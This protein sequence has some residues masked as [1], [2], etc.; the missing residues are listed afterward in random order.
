MTKFICCLLL[1]LAGSVMAP[2]QYKIEKLN[3]I[4]PDKLKLSDGTL[5]YELLGEGSPVVLLH[6]GGLDLHMWDKQANTFAKHFRI[7]RY[8]L[9]GHGQSAPATGTFSDV[10]DLKMLLDH[11]GYKKVSLV[12]LSRG[13]GVALNFTLDHPERVDKLVLVSASGPPPGVPVAEGT[14]VLTDTATHYRLKEIGVPVLI[15]VGDGDSPRVVGAAD[16]AVAGIKGARKVVIPNARHLVN[17]ENQRA[18]DE[19]VIRFLS[20]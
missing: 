7:I 1:I 13:S 2:A 11:L 18:F 14:V 3:D 19:E 15:V 12:G 10:D 16:A 17:V 9:R 6:G 4:K 5:Y 20:K 8:D